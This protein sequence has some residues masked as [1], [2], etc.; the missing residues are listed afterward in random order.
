MGKKRKNKNNREKIISIK[1]QGAKV[2]L[3]KD[4]CTKEHLNR[5]LDSRGRTLLHLLVSRKGENDEWFFDKDLCD[6]LI[7]KEMDI[8]SKD[9]RGDTPL[10]EA[11]YCGNAVAVGYLLEKGADS[12]S[13]SSGV[14]DPNRD[15]TAW[16][17][18]LWNGHSDCMNL[19]DEDLRNKIQ[20][21][22]THKATEES[23]IYLKS[24]EQC[25]E[26]RAR[27]I[28]VR[29]FNILTLRSDKRFHQLR[30]DY[31]FFI[32]T[33]DCHKPIL[34]KALSD[35]GKTILHYL[36]KHK[37]DVKL[38]Q[39]VVGNYQEY[40]I[41]LLA[42]DSGG[43][44]ALDYLIDKK[45][46][47]LIPLLLC[48]MENYKTQCARNKLEEY[49]IKC[50][51]STFIDFIGAS[52]TM[53]ILT[54]DQAVLIGKLVL[55]VWRCRQEKQSLDEKKLMIKSISS[56]VQ[57]AIQSGNENDLSDHHKLVQLFAVIVWEEMDSEAMKML[58]WSPLLMN[59]LR[60]D[61]SQTKQSVL[62]A[63]NCIASHHPEL[64]LRVWRFG[65]S[66]GYH[67]GCSDSDFNQILERMRSNV[68][69]YSSSLVS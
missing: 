63:L 26:H 16:H 3:Y 29:L 65:E 15:V 36:V 35:D 53:Q 12:L 61:Q 33:M 37:R 2:V 55:K 22:N 9:K 25:V 51:N 8:E 69:E 44:T 4:E 28:K 13:R 49:F 27:E 5:P 54:S 67:Q 14:A 46:F 45:S 17:W 32:R 43:K 31:N 19:L 66:N 6:Q 48:S 10:S 11:A 47:N 60:F 59:P 62:N 42:E 52:Y 30:G 64:F 56:M 1:T 21:V 57:K 7:S 38:L 39:W 18:A 68:D 34:S 40:G 24:L 50:D 20:D 41:N 23:K 58:S